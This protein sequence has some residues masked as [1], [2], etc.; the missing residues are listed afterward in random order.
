MQDAFGQLSSQKKSVQ[1]HGDTQKQLAL[2]KFY[3]KFKRWN[4]RNTR[5]SLVSLK[6]L[7]D[8]NRLY[9]RK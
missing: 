2:A 9:R 5:F 3:L 7:M 1:G 4:P 6:I 8:V